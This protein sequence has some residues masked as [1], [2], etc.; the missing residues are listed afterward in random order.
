V[1]VN[2]LL[3]HRDFSCVSGHLT[4]V[5]LYCAHDWQIYLWLFEIFD[6]YLSGLACS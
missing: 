6:Y 4:A 5:A 1:A 2:E 3:N